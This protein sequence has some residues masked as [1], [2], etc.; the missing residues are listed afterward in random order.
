M[1]PYYPSIIHQRHISHADILY[2]THVGYV[3]NCAP[4]I[5]DFHASHTKVCAPSR[6]H[7]RRIAKLPYPPP[8]YVP[9]WQCRYYRLL[10]LSTYADTRV[11]ATVQ[12]SGP[13]LFLQTV[14]SFTFAISVASESVLYRSI[15]PLYVY[16]LFSR[17][18]IKVCSVSSTAHSFYSLWLPLCWSIDTSARLSPRQLSAKNQLTHAMT[19]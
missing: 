16:H 18:T 15:C 6:L 19:Q 12:P 2:R 17:T 11:S 8:G 5:P 9:P 10:R 1:N 4:P 7:L 3:T 14:C 13:G